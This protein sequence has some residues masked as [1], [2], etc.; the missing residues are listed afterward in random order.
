MELDRRIRKEEDLMPEVVKPGKPTMQYL[1]TG[2]VWVTPSKSTPGKV[3]VTVY[4]DATGMRD[5]T[6]EG[7]R[8]QKN[9]WHL[10]AITQDNTDDFQVNL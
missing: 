2:K 5:C 4:N 9:C 7:W 8:Y 6:C 10:K 3:H 1:G